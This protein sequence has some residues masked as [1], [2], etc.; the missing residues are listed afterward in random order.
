VRVSEAVD[1]PRLAG[2]ML[3]RRGSRP[4]PSVACREPRGEP[5]TRRT[6]DGRPIQKRGDASAGGEP[7]R[8]PEKRSPAAREQKRMVFRETICAMI[9]LQLK[10][11]RDGMFPHYPLVSRRE[12]GSESA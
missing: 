2:R 10:A 3:V 1:T 8:R 11:S 7:P 9:P 4:S 6:E 12:R 5:Y